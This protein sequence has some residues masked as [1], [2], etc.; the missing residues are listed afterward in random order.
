M[1]AAEF[2]GAITIGRVITVAKKRKKR[3][4]RRRI[5]LRRSEHEPLYEA[6]L[7]AVSDYVSNAESAELLAKMA[8][9]YNAILD[10]CGSDAQAR[11]SAAN[12]F[13]CMEMGKVQVYLPK[14]N[15]P[16]SIQEAVRLLNYGVPL[17]VNGAFHVRKRDVYGKILTIEGPDGEEI[18]ANQWRR[19]HPMRLTSDRI[20]RLNLD[21]DNLSRELNRMFGE[22]NK[23]AFDEDLAALMKRIGEEIEKRVW[24]F[25]KAL[26]GDFGEELE[27]NTERSELIAGADLTFRGMFKEETEAILG[28]QQTGVLPSLF[29]PHTHDRI[30]SVFHSIDILVDKSGST[31]ERNVYRFVDIA[32]AAAMAALERHFPQFLCRVV[33]YSD[34]PMAPTRKLEG[35]ISPDGPTHYGN[36]FTYSQNH[37]QGQSGAKLV[38]HL[39]DGAPN[40]QDEALK[41]AQYFPDLNIQFGQIIFGHDIT[42]LGESMQRRA[43]VEGLGCDPSVITMRD[44]EQVFTDVNNAAKGNQVILWVTE[45]MADM[46]YSMID[47]G[48]GSFFHGKGATH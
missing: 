40:D 16:L 18:P 8:G 35:F 36:V 3:K 11:Q 30:R 5:K 44:Y 19:R 34:E 12:L 22:A 4:A 15:A 17:E 1:L 29:A 38:I 7:E 31:Q 39:S 24:R 42:D 10:L 46:I 9:E 37:L 2:L 32:C 14:L 43:L 28:L 45:A 41:A 20:D 6:V 13:K 23:E 33:P 48:I 47:L 27:V 26:P 25:Y 21:H